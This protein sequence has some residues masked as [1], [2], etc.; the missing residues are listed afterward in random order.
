MTKKE[1]ESQAHEGNIEKYA[2]NTN[3]VL[4]IWHSHRQKQATYKE[5]N[6]IYSSEKRSARSKRIVIIKEKADRKRNIN[7]SRNQSRTD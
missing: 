1:T 6:L 7:Q 5:Q 4:K 2:Y 3:E